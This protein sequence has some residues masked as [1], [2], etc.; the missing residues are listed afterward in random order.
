VALGNVLP[1][2]PTKINGIPFTGMT[3][4]RP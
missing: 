3:P 4:L 1:C 2:G